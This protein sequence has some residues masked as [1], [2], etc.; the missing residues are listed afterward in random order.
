MRDSLR[1]TTVCITRTRT[2]SIGLAV[3]ITRTRTS[4]ISLAVCGKTTKVCM[5][6]TTISSISLPVCRQRC[7]EENE[8][9]ILNL[10]RVDHRHDEDPDQTAFSVV[11]HE[12]FG[13]VEVDTNIPYEVIYTNVGGGW[14]S[15]TNAFHVSVAGVYMFT[16]TLVSHTDTNDTYVY[17]KMIHSFDG[18]QTQV[19]TLEALGSSFTGHACSTILQLEVGE[20][21]SVKLMAGERKIHSTSAGPRSTF[22]GFLLFKSN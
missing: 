5:T 8:S 3:C 9:D 21:V 12:D 11:S 17:G 10:Q 7:M 15:T 6:R 2:S 18:G 1:T 16:A 19:T 20:A 14:S 4:S 22:S 13:P